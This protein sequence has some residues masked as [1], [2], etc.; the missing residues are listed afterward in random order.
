[1]VPF[2]DAIERLFAV[3][4]PLGQERVPFEKAANRVLAEDLRA[5]SDAP[6]FD[7]AAMD[8]YGV[9]E[10]DLAA[11]PQDLPLIGES[12]AGSALMD[13]VHECGC[14]RI[15]TGAPVPPA[16]DRVIIQEHVTRD[17][18]NVHF[19]RA[20][21]AGRNIRKQG[22][23][24]KAGDVLLAKGTLINWRAMTTAAAADQGHLNVFRRPKVAI[25]A[26]GDEL[27]PPG[28]AHEQNG[29]IPE[30]IS[31]GL[32]IF[33]EQN[34]ADVLRSERLA[35]QPDRLS[36]AASRALNDADLVV[37]TGGA[38]VGERDYARTMFGSDPLDYV[39]SKVAIKPGKPVWLARRK[40]R[41][42]LG[43]PGNPGSALVIARLFLAPLLAGMTGQNPKAAL[44]F[45]T[46]KSR[47]ALRSCGDRDTFSRAYREDGFAVLCNTQDSSAQAVLAQANILIRRPAHAAAVPAGADLDVI[48]F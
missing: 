28:R 6:A 36:E 3:A 13:G 16:I 2:D 25:L 35:D 31:F 32:R 33:A 7:V 37:V 12:F 9:R 26:T 27:A 43:V 34:G 48:E 10:S 23:D 40:G 4:V 39:F 22:S 15:F 1:M 24:F 46:L 14:I 17:G 19:S 38:S 20:L 18:N 47:N 42:I 11:L 21:G 29:R 41:L 8:G 30:S 5:R 44:K 45:N